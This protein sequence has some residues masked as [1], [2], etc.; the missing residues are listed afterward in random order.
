MAR[1]LEQGAQAKARI[2]SGAAC[3]ISD[4]ARQIAGETD[5]S[6][7][8]IRS[9]LQ[10]EGTDAVHQLSELSGT[11]KHRPKTEYQ[12]EI[13]KEYRREKIDQKQKSEGVTLSHLTQKYTP[14]T[15]YQREIIKERDKLN[16]EPLTPIRNRQA[17]AYFT[18]KK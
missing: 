2:E 17:Q 13:I 16:C 14:K 7:H 11:A 5:R 10:R 12:K 8:A 15:E 9:A 18:K 3:S 1:C 4:A 6:P